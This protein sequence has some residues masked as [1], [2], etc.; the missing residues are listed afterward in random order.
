MKLPFLISLLLP[1]S[2]FAQRT[3]EALYESH[4]VIQRFVGKDVPVDLSLSLKKQKGC[5]KF[6][7]TVK[8]GRLKIQGSSGVALCRGF[9]DYVKGQN[10]GICSWSGK[11]VAWPSRLKN[12]PAREVV[13]PFQHHYNFNVVT[14]GYTMPYWDWA[15]WE[16]EIDWMALHG[17]DMPLALVANEAITARV[18]RKLGLSDAEI[19]AYFVGPAH[20]PWMRMGNIS[21]IDGPLPQEWHQDQI[22]LQH[23]IL[24]RMKSL[25][26]KPICPGFA[27]FVPQ[28]LGR[29]YPEIKLIETA[30]GG[31]F[32]N[33]MLS[34]DQPLFKKIGQLFIE[35]WEKEFGKN[36]YYLV[37]SFNEMEIPFPPKD[38]PARYS[39]LSN[40]GKAVYASIQAGSPDAVWVMQGWMFG[41]QRNIWD[42]KT[43]QALVSHVPDDK[44]LL[45]DL[46]VDYNYRFWRNGSNW[47][48]YKGF[49]H[50][51][52]VY[53]VIPNMGGKTG[54]TGDLEFYANGR[55][56][57]L[58]SPHKGRLVGYGMA[59]EGIENNE[60]IYELICDGGWTS[61]S[62]PLTPW[63]EQYTL[64]RYGQMPAELN[65]YWAGLL[66]SVYGSF[67][68]HPRYN[69]QFRPGLVQKGS[70]NANDSFY[71]GVEALASGARRLKQSPLYVLDLTEM[72]AH[73]VGGKME[74]LLQ[75]IEKA[76]TE[77]D[78]TKA[79]ALQK[80]FVELALGIDRVLVQHPT[81]QLA[82]WLDFAKG[83]GATPALKRYYERNARRLV[84]IWGPP[85]EDYS[86]RLWSGLIRDYYV[87]RWLHYFEAKRT[88]KKFDFVAWERKW[89]E[90]ETGLS[91]VQP[92]ADPVEACVRWI[93]K[94]KP[95]SSALIQDVAGE[96][97]GSW[98]AAEVTNDWKTIEWSV[99][100]D[101]VAKAK[102]VRFDYVRGAN[103]LMIKTV[104]L[105][106]DGKVVCHDEHDGETGTHH[107]ANVYRLDVPRE[108]TGNNSCVLRATVKS[109]GLHDSYGHVS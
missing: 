38:T 98:A 7:Y 74:I 90:E 76:S 16:T 47:D 106:M 82:R 100:V 79:A 36:K 30:W 49:Y 41:Y 70:I 105:V 23:K 92:Y 11:R 8:N 3:Q 29:I 12:Q 31:A 51:E 13:S 91:A 101:Q 75:A 65:A 107:R 9:Y 71:K 62:I 61:D 83:H 14:Y 35:E 44:M 2:L 94:A 50:K 24:H 88:G 6:V 72:T 32:H 26:M 85:V 20:F 78:T 108:A 66:T 34:P 81:L 64:C 109:D 46:A 22:D 54:L 19:S 69:W 89:V 27:G 80:T 93:E 99:S 95:I 104:T 60:V 55:L 4:Q 43:L 42:Y 15:R 97:I 84:T 39:L 58:H 33:W 5:D 53:S 59:P 48:L 67:T 17:Q 73:Y 45:L 37:D 1:L 56:A 63:L 52:W 18:W 102:G 103:K 77:N 21:G 86:A 87:P 25:G 68:D 57:A 10:A 96:K 28:S 40:Y